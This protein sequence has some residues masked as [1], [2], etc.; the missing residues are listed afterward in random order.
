MGR[1]IVRALVAVTAAA[2]VVIFASTQAQAA[3]DL[4][5][6][7]DICSVVTGQ[8]I[9]QTN[10]DAGQFVQFWADDSQGAVNNTWNTWL[11]AGNNVV[12]CNT[13]F[14]FYSVPASTCNAWGMNGA[15]VVKL[16]WAPN[17]EG[18]G[19]CIYAGDYDGS[20]YHSVL[21]SECSPDHSTDTAYLYAVSKLGFVVSA[22]ATNYQFVGG[23][24]RR[25]YLG[26][27]SYADNSES[28]GSP[29]CLT[30]SNGIAWS[31]RP[32]AL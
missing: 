17:D 9:N 1:N 23:N 29:I 24:D 26:T 2:S 16:A 20:D 5:R 3:D 25:V 13:G 6:Q 32:Q 8:C 11:V 7:G 10:G 30:Y 31:W 22:Y 12:N 28:S 14:P 21:T 19:Y 27:C 18:S 15:L 4:F